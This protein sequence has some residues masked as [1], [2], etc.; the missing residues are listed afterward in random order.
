M[1]FLCLFVYVCVLTCVRFTNTHIYMWIPSEARKGYWSLWSYRR[2]WAIQL[3][4]WETNSIPLQEQQ[5]LLIS[6]PSL[7]FYFIL[8]LMCRF[9]FF[10][11]QLVIP[12]RPCITFM[13]SRNF[14]PRKQITICH[15]FPVLE[16][17]IRVWQKLN[18]ASTTELC[19]QSLSR[20]SWKWFCHL[21]WS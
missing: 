11:T 2:L 15:S 9:S 5:A 4:C 13:F 21:R 12:I 3:E 18:K 7:Q 6:D 1:I 19:P 17:D 10:N 20:F 16:I 8:Y 14:P